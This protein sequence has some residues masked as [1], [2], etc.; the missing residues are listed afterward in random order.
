M[1]NLYWIIDKDGHRVAFKP[2]WA[3]L[4]LLDDLHNQNL[5]LKARQLGFTTFI[6]IFMLDACLFNSNIRAG[7]IAHR[8]DDAKVIFRDKI[9]FPYDNLPDG[10]KA[11]R[12]VVRD[13]A[14]E[15]LFNNNSSIRVGVS[16]RSG[17]LQYL[18]I[19]E[20]GQVC[21]RFP[22]KAREIRTGAL[23][24]VQA[25]QTVFI[26]STAEG[27]EG[28]FY[29]LCE[30]AQSKVR[31]GTALSSLDF[32]FGF[33]PWWQAPEYALEPTGVIID[34]LHRKYFEK[35]RDMSGI[36]LT[37]AQQAWYVK[38]AEIQ[39]GDMKREFPSTPEEAFEASVEGA[40]YAEPMATAELQQRIGTFKA[41]PDIPVNTAWDIGVGDANA[42]W[43]W[44][45][46]HGKIGLVGY[47]EN[48]GEGL[49]FYAGKLEEYAKRLGWKY[50]KHLV[51]HDAKVLE[52]G[53]G[54][55]R[56]E[57]LVA[58]GIR[59][60]LVP[61]H[62]IDDGINAVRATLPHCYFDAEECAEG[63]KALKGY[64]KEW[65]EDRACFRDKPLHNWA[66]NGAD[67]F[68]YL[69]MAWKDLQPDPVEPTP[70]DIV[71]EMTRPRTFNEYM[72]EL[73]EEEALELS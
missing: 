12:P 66:S 5:I 22:E 18:H 16:M 39:L 73:E 61:M 43:F 14:D 1:D 64:K 15:L 17:T 51:P 67:S 33:Y 37:P 55:T 10:I 11:L 19:S 7:T 52:W 29:D 34:E 57:Q 50:G 23:N 42:I 4:A 45:K 36:E 31:L 35:L 21:A 69:S 32:K 48:N 62:R 30:A 47:Y 40:Y 6:Q 72:E 53:A 54:R 9:K 49:P 70:A 13:A 28:H 26:E 71:K 24:T 46:M 56:L 8:L 58:N 65:D 38:K 44:Q 2:N 41:L 59:P 68:R 25:G 27:K 20:Y 63:V 60:T 3:Q